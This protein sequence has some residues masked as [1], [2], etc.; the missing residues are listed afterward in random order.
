MLDDACY[1]LGD[2]SAAFGSVESDG[3]E[4]ASFE[5]AYHP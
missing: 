5:K 4:H 2:K 1:S 3:E